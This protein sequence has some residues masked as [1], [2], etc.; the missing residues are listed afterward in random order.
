[1][2]WAQGQNFFVYAQYVMMPGA[3]GIA[4]YNCQ[5]C[6]RLRS[7]GVLRI[8]KVIKNVLKNP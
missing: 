4:A 7:Q 8:A 2:F 3:K 6:L 5:N 1:M